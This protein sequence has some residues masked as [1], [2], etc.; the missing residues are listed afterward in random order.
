MQTEGG[1]RDLSGEGFNLSG[2]VLSRIDIVELISEYV[3]LKKKG[4]T[5]FGLCPF[6]NDRN[7]SMSVSETKQIFKCF[8][9]GVGGNAI[10]FV[11]LAEKMTYRDALFSLA[12]KAGIE[13]K[14]SDADY[15]AKN[16]LRQEI[17]SLNKNAARFFH[18][19][20]NKSA[21]AIAYINERKIA[22]DIVRRFGLGYAPEGWEAL[23]KFFAE[24]GV[25]YDL[26]LKA[27]LISSSQKNN[28]M[29]YYDR[30]V[31]RLMFPI[32]DDLGNVIGF[33]GRIIEEK[34]KMAKY[35]NSAETPVYI[36]GSSLYG[37]NFAKKSGSERVII[38]EGYMD[39]IALHQKGITNTVASLGTALT[40]Q[41]AKLLKKYFTE[42]IIAYDAD[43]AGK[44]ATLRGMDIL[45]A[46]GFK[47]KVF[48]LQG[49]KD[50]DEYLKGHSSEDF[51]KQLGSAQPLIEYKISLLAAEF[52]PNSNENKVQFISRADGVLSDN[53]IEREVYADWIVK[54]YGEKYGIEKRMLLR[55]N[56]KSR[57]GSFAEPEE[58]RKPKRS[59]MNNENREEARKEEE[60]KIDFIEKSLLI[61]LAEDMNCMKKM[62]PELRRVP[63]FIPEN[64]AALEMLLEAGQNG[65]CPGSA[66][67]MQG[68]REDSAYAGILMNFIFPTDPVKACKELLHKLEVQG[69]ERRKREI[70]QLLDSGTLDR[71]TQMALLRELKSLS[72][73]N[74][75]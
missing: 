13:Y 7:P 28:Q 44:N 23:T 1:E 45:K 52:P 2:E 39:C 31:D 57:S 15:E 74:N 24:A 32:F 19:S 36:K 41:Q 59:F 69:N 64:K 61:I 73:R 12:D 20:L 63:F 10:K 50:A 6:H 62:T 75:K 3:T 16:K 54:E 40:P 4:S 22:P 67:L 72:G 26:L 30:F 65:E 60:K 14:R 51:L 42:A 18:D 43:D 71:Q 34:D 21:K 17:L 37:L 29:R 55:K 25:S 9:C 8:S 47:V 56:T 33:G 38:V 66:A 58:P 48:R 27:G 11:S 49:A 46:E 70:T 35:I 5:Y 53:E 68:D